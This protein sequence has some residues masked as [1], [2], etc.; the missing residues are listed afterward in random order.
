M[1]VKRIILLL[2]FAVAT[3]LTLVS[4]AGAGNFDEPRMGCQGEAPATCATGTVA[5]PYSM[6]VR[7]QDDEDLGCAVFKVSSGGLPPGLMLTPYANETNAGFISGTPT[8][9]GTFSFYLTV[10]YDKHTGCNKPTS[11]DSFV[12]TI[13]PEVP[14]LILQPEQSGVP[15]STVGAPYSLQMTSNLPDSKAWSVSGQL[16]PGLNIDASSGLISGT[17]T[18]A[19]QYPFTVQAVLTN[20]TLKSPPRSDTKALSITVSDPLT[21]TG[22]GGSGSA[23]LPASEVGV[24]FDA[25]FTVSGGTGTYGS[26]TLTSGTLP[27]GVTLNAD[28]SLSGTPREA[29]RFLFSV[30]VT[31]T[32]VPTPRSANSSGV[33]VVAAK[34]DVT[35]QRLRP[36]RV[37]KLY[38]AKLVSAG[39]VQPKLWRVKGRLPRGVKLNR[40]T[41]VLRG[42]PKKAGTYR[43]TVEVTDSLKVKSTQP[44]VIVVVTARKA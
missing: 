38:R 28:G 13:N 7:L 44:L 8:Q 30:G 34:L 14:K 15:A 22:P 35:T 20:D 36:G 27:R 24:L 9:A 37:G 18:T 11:D 23:A 25:S 6:Q 3:S 17:P 10:T 29:G 1:G 5:Q 26:W 41:G 4:A 31:D 33:I 21:I 2:V 40:T 43:I 19:G 39:G 16:P 12:I 32:E 42:T